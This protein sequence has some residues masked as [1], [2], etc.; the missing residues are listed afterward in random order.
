MC[1]EL[2][3]NPTRVLSRIKN[4]KVSMLIAGA[5][6]SDQGIIGGGKAI[7]LTCESL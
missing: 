4:N 2:L 7:G 6:V 5:R 3:W 1:L